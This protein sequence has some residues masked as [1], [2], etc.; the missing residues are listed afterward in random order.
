[1]LTTTKGNAARD[2]IKALKL[3]GEEG[4]NVKLNR[5]EGMR[6]MYDTEAKSLDYILVG[7]HKTD[8][9]F[10]TMEYQTAEGVVNFPTPIFP[11]AFG[12]ELNFMRAAI[13]AHALAVKG[14]RYFVLGE[15]EKA[16]K[17]YES[18]LIFDF[19]DLPVSSGSL[20]T[21]YSLVRCAIRRAITCLL[22]K[23]P[24]K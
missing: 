4:E 17:I 18:I 22:P 8:C 9:D 2:Y 1:M 14:D 15:V 19:L 11:S 20:A 5:V 6:F 3:R 21:I 16:R 13:F 12:I 7:A 10:A 24:G 23:N